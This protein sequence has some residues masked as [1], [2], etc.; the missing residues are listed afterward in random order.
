M[1]LKALASDALELIASRFRLLGEPMRLRILMALKEGEKNVSELVESTGGT[2][3]NI[4][5]HL[6]SLTEGGILAR[7]KEG[8]N[9]FY[10]VDDPSIYSLCDN[11]CG[12]LQKRLNQQTKVLRG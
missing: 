11:V 1:A 6:Q 7:R 5:R 12:S 2:Q 3:A 4:S 9:V 8:L 10:S